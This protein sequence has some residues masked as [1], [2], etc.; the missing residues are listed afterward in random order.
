MSNFYKRFNSVINQGGRW[1][2]KEL[3]QA[4]KEREGLVRAAL[5]KKHK[6]GKLKKRKQEYW[7]P[8]KG[9]KKC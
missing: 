3:A 6:A 9:R 1:T 8:K 4:L 5:K 2:S 7:K